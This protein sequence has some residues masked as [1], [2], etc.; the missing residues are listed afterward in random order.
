MK[1][2]QSIFMSL[3]ILFIFTSS[4]AKPI[5]AGFGANCDEEQMANFAKFGLNTQF[6]CVRIAPQMKLSIDEKG[7]MNWQI[8]DE[9]RQNY[10][11]AA[12]VAQEHGI[13]LYFV[14][15]YFAEYVEQLTALGPFTKAFVQGPTRYISTGEK[16]R[17][18]AA[19]RAVLAWPTSM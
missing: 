13:D 15:G 4:Q 18:R 11:N 14:T 3:S 2:S 19:G 7:Q 10:I 12:K 16:K 17:T 5:I 1:I 6:L 9:K 8:P